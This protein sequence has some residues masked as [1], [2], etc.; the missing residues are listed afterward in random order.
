MPGAMVDRTAWRIGKRSVVGVRQMQAPEVR[1]KAGLLIRDDLVQ[2]EF[3][4]DAPNCFWLTDITEHGLVEGKFYLCVIKDV[5]SNRVVGDLIGWRMKSRRMANAINSATALCDGIT[6]CVMHGDR[7]G[8]FRSR[9]VIR[10][11]ALS[12]RT[13]WVEL[14]RQ[15]ITLQWG[16]SSRYC[17]RMSQLAGSE[18]SGKAADRD[19]HL[20]GANLPP[21]PTT[22]TS[23]LIG[24]DRIR[25]SHEYDCRPGGVNRS[26]HLLHA[27]GL[28]IP[29]R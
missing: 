22:G 20:D 5:F 17:R 21:K 12:V 14:A 8:Q 9:K 4:A 25:D 28:E 26:C 2:R 7:G 13:Q 6:A 24:G 27:V 18:R 29:R 16:H 11:L 1:R 3:V 15:A 10:D 19:R 23:G